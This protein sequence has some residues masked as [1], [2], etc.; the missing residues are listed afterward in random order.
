MRTQSS[1]VPEVEFLLAARL[2]NICKHASGYI[3]FEGME[4]SW[5]AVEAGCCETAGKVIGEGLVP[6]TDGDPRTEMVMQRRLH[7]I[8]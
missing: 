3:G 1:C 6:V 5:T 8:S 4:G 7:L 2:D